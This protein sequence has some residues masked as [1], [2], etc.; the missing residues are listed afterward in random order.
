MTATKA[1]ARR[2]LDSH[3]GARIDTVQEFPSPEVPPWHP[4]TRT[5]TK[6]S[7]DVWMMDTSALVLSRTHQV[8]AVTD[9]ALILAWHDD[10]GRL[11]HTT[12]YV[13][14]Q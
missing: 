6:R 2:W 12:T 11:L 9:D 7:R 13:V 10:Q 5:L 14:A 4:R 1:E 8:V 3:L